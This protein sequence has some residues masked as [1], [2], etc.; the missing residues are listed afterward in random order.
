MARSMTNVHN[1]NKPSMMPWSCCGVSSLYMLCW[2]WLRKHHVPN[3]FAANCVHFKNAR[4]IPNH[5]NH[6]ATQIAWTLQNKCTHTHTVY[7]SQAFLNYVENNCILRYE[8]HTGFSCGIIFKMWLDIFYD[9]MCVCPPKS[10]VFWNLC[11]YFVRSL[12]VDC[13]YVTEY[14]QKLKLIYSLQ[15]IS[16]IHNKTCKRM[17]KYK[18]SLSV[19]CI[20]KLNT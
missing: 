19:H 15:K 13:C 2:K 9:F 11:T 5:Q 18:C 12:L 16:S 20:K 8:I 7:M 1:I 4:A 6:W 10:L 17:W 14:T 3:I